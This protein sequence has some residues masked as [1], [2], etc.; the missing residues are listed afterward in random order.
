MRLDLSGDEHVVRACA[1]V[2][3]VA[4]PFP[5][6]VMKQCDECDVDIWVDPHQTMRDPE[7]GEPVETTVNLCVVCTMVH[8]IMQG[9]GEL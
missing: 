1:T 6:S 7:T 9:R 3:E 8:V 5:G 2:K 4:V